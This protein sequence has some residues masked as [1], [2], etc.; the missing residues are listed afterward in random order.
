VTQAILGFIENLPTSLQELFLE[1]NGEGLWCDEDSDFDPVCN[2]GTSIFDA[3]RNLHT[4]DIHAWISNCD[5][6]LG[7]IPEKGVFYRRLSH[8][9]KTRDDVPGNKIK[10]VWTS[11]MDCIYQ[12]NDRNVTT[13]CVEVE[14]KDHEGVFGGRDAN[15]VWC[16]GF[17]FADNRRGHPS[18]GSDYSWPFWEDKVGSYEMFRKRH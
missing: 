13:E 10:D 11:R 2:L 15:E 9:S 14:L 17:E 8:Q 16:D 5:G 4:C 7:Q 6:G 12:E 18:G 1:I 3:L